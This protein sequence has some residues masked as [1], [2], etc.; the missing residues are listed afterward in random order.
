MT[1]SLDTFKDEIDRAFRVLGAD[2]GF[3]QNVADIMNWRQEGFL[4]EDEYKELRH[5]NR[6]E[7]AKLP[8]DA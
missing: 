4:T 1:I 6:T 7:Y 8:L 5:Y 2:R 3:V